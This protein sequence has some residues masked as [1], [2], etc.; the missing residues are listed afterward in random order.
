MLKPVGALAA[1]SDSSGLTKWQLNRLVPKL[2]MH[3]MAYAQSSERVLGLMHNPNIPVQLRKGIEAVHTHLAD[4]IPPVGEKLSAALGSVKS[5]SKLA[6][7]HGY[8]GIASDLS[9]FNGHLKQ[10]A[11]LN[12]KV[13]AWGNLKETITAPHSLKEMQLA[14]GVGNALWGAASLTS[15]YVTGKDIQSDIEAL[16]NLVADV[17]HRKAKDISFDQLMFETLPEPASSAR[18]HLV[19]TAGPRA[20]IESASVL[21]NLN[22]ALRGG[23]FLLTMI[24]QVIGQ[25]IGMLTGGGM[26]DSYKAMKANEQFHHPNPPE[27]YA[28]LLGSSSKELQ[29]RGGETSRFAQALGKTYAERGY[30][31]AQTLEAVANGQVLKDIEAMQSDSHTQSKSAPE[32]AEFSHAAAVRKQPAP[33]ALAQAKEPGGAFAQR[34]HTD[35]Q[36]SKSL[37]ASAQMT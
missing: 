15:A 28:K 17:T 11:K 13:H 33:Q 36:Q 9:A 4:G 25:G 22:M 14:H 30:T 34:L 3:H 8:H 31:V 32:K 16:R 6:K 12:H 27:L 29:E 23:S 10:T 35:R 24:P 21:F 26:L 7:Q 1:L 5:A 19:K 2:E 20:M 18:W 37:P